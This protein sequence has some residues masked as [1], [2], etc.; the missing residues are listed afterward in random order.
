M[1]DQLIAR[2]LGEFRA[3]QGE[4]QKLR[5]RLAAAERRIGELEARVEDE[6][7]QPPFRQNPAHADMV[8]ERQREA[9]AA[10]VFG[11]APTDDEPFPRK[12]GERGP[13]YQ[14]SNGQKVRGK[15]EAQAMQ[16]EIDGKTQPQG[17]Q[18][19]Q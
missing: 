13:F 16:D 3:F 15:A 19:S 1:T 17:E 8:A 10:Q 7:K 5:N 18:P 14:L 9:R 6:V 2:V 4:H 12:W 11:E